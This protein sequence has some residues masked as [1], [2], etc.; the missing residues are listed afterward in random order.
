MRKRT[1]KLRNK[2][3]FKGITNTQLIDELKS[4]FNNQN[5]KDV[6]DHITSDSLNAKK[7]W[8]DFKRPK[9][10]KLTPSEGLALL[11]ELNLTHDQY[12]TLIKI[13]KKKHFAILPSLDAIK[14]E[15]KN[16]TLQMLKVLRHI[17]KYLC[18]IIWTIH[19]KD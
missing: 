14:A 2:S 8:N 16:V 4:R 9:P 3:K 17:S 18:R 6:I 13:L 10:I 12:D 7:I 1:Q 19:L 15:K 11:T 5:F